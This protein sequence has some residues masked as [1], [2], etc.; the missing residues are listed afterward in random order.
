MEQWKFE[1]P[2]VTDFEDQHVDIQADLSNVESF[3][4]FDDVR[5]ELIINDLSDNAIESGFYS[6]VITLDDGENEV[7]E[8]IIIDVRDAPP[9]EEPM[10]ELEEESELEESPGTE[11]SDESPIAEMSETTLA[12]DETDQSVFDWRTA[13]IDLE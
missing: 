4:L 11:N 12:Q 8:T 7:V 2:S 1:L 5:R 3:M 9:L 13:F 10:P 6:I